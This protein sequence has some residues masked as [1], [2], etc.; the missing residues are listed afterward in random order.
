ML[1]QE[2]EGGAPANVKE[3]REWIGAWRKS[4]SGSGLQ[5]VQQAGVGY[6]E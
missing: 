3:A 2:E 4:S 1:Q 6:D 5:Q